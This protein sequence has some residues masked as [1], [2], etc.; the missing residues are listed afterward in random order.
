MEPG[1]MYFFVALFGFIIGKDISD[2]IHHNKI[3]DRL[4]DIYNKI[5]Y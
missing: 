4:D 2:A 1:T 5:R 3:M